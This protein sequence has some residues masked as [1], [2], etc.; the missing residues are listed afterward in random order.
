MSSLPIGKLNELKNLQFGNNPLRFPPKHVLNG[1][2]EAIKCYFGGKPVKKVGSSSSSSKRSVSSISTKRSDPYETSLVSMASD[3]EISTLISKETDPISSSTSGLPAREKE[4]EDDTDKLDTDSSCEGSE[5]S[6][7]LDEE[8]LCQCLSPKSM[9]SVSSCK[10]STYETF[11][12]DNDEEPRRLCEVLRK[13]ENNSQR[14]RSLHLVL[15][16]S[17]SF[18]E[19][20]KDRCFR[21]QKIIRKKKNAM[22]VGSE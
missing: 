11:I 2:L 10:N 1:G 5:I 6:S 22:P 20:L 9:S 12:E 15:H 18:D 14:R 3:K 13:E 8:A 19:E 16:Q 7:Q 21:C 4:L 17:D